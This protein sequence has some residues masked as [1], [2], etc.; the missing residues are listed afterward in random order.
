MSVAIKEKPC[1]MDL[2]LTQHQRLSYEQ[3]AALKGKTLSQWS[4]AALDSAAQYDINNA[5][6]TMLSA[7]AF[8]NF[9]SILEQPLPPET[10]ELLARKEIWA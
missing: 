1:R 9:C 7:E 10:Q 6:I 8:E 2:R 4:T 5:T 3:A